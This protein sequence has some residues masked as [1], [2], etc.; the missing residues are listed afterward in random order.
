MTMLMRKIDKCGKELRKW[1]RDCFGNVK[2]ILSQKR[3]DL[4]EAKNW[5]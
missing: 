3:K 4:K 5:L 2:V 1:E